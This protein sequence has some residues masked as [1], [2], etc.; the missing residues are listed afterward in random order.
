MHETKCRRPVASGRVSFPAALVFSAV[1][2]GSALL[3]V[4]ASSWLLLGSSGLALFLALTKGR[5]DLATG[6]GDQ[7]PRGLRYSGMV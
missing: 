4:A 5:A 1:L 2:L 3:G 7:S 6:V